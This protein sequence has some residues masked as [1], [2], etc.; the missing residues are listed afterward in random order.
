[1]ISW[2]SLSFQEGAKILKTDINKGLSEKEVKIRQKR[3]GKNLIPEED[4]FSSFKIFLEQFQSPLIYIL[5]IA[6]IITL[7]IGKWTDTIVIFL[8]VLIS[9]IFGF[10]EEYKVARTLRKLKK[11]LKTKAVVLRDGIKKVVCQEEIVPGD[12]IFISRGNRVPAD[13]RLISAENLQ[14]SEAFLTGEW[15]PSFKKTK[16]LPKE[17]SLAD[18]E[19]MI[20]QGSLVEEGEG[21]A[22]VTATGTQTEAGKIA[23]L[24]KETKREKTPLQKKLI[25]FS[26]IVGI[27]IGALAGVLFFIG[28]LRGIDLLEM[29]ET[30][31]AIAV[32]G[33]PEALP[34]VMIVILAVGMERILKKKG[35]VRRLNS[36]ETLGSAEI[37]LFDKTKTL[38]KGKMAPAEVLAKDKNL[39]LKIAV[40]ANEAFIENP[41]DAPRFWKIRGSPTDIALIEAGKKEGIFKI[42]LEKKSQE[43]AKVPF[44]SVWKYQISFRKEKEKI[45]LYI[46]GAPERILEKS[47]EKEKWRKLLEELTK[48]GRRVV[49]TGYREISAQ[50]F[51]LSKD[52]HQLA[53]DLEFSGLIAFKDP[54]REEVPEAIKICRLAGITPV[55]VTG[56]HRLTAKAVA[57]EIGLDIKE[58]DILEGKEL[59]KLSEEELFQ[60]LEKIK[61][62]ARVEPKHK[63]RIVRAWQRKGKVVAMIGDGVNDAPALKKANIGVALGSGTEVAKDISDLVLLNDSFEIIIKAIEEGRIILD[64]IRK[65]ITYVMANSFASAIIV[66]GATVLGW[67]LPILAV[68]ILWNNIVEDSLPNLAYAFEPGEKGIMR[69]KPTALSTSLLTREMKILIFATGTIY[70]SIALL[71]FWILWGIFGFALEYVR[72]MVFGVLVV[73]TAFVIFSYKSLRQNIFNYNLFSNKIL[74]LSAII[75]LL[76]FVASIYLPPFQIILKTSPLS[77]GSW[78][79]LIAISLA[80]VALIEATKFYFIKKGRVE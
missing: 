73:N 9:S 29:F 16:S 68:Q 25:E 15:F 39:A 78:L 20:Y 28:F 58:K 8:S 64:N 2:H 5:V 65:G 6:G 45:F 11:I 24:I 38:T 51:Q 19:N 1:M 79:I 61:V 40:L 57:Q 67:P 76:F 42:E 66:G 37:I 22:I 27:F 72:T 56:D 32:G 4:S 44:S 69:R 33:I 12:I 23:F 14:I 70:Q 41:K 47:R 35:L 74:N 30:A 31:V 13:G 52:F 53:K 71:L 46:T 10:F 43:L 7:I 50:E 48:K 63:V 3:F 17:I 60:K 36:V 54:L 34:I 55:M 49:G 26:K 80:S 21:K 75:V 18:R 62:Y 59:D 77:F